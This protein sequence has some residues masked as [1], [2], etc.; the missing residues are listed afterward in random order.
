MA[1]I[2]TIIFTFIGWK[3]LDV[4][5]SKVRR[6]GSIDGRLEKQ[7]LK[8]SNIL[9][10]IEITRTS[11]VERNLSD[12]IEQFANEIKKISATI[13]SYD[14][15]SII[16]TDLT[17]P[18]S[19][20]EE[21]SE[22]NINII[23]SIIKEGQNNQMAIDR[24]LFV[25]QEKSKLL[26]Q[27]NVISELVSDE[28]EKLRLIMDLWNISL[29]LMSISFMFQFYRKS[30]FPIAKSIDALNKEKSNLE[31]LLEETQN[32][33]ESGLWEI[34]F[35]K[36]ETKWS[37]LLY[38]IF[39]VDE[40][41]KPS[42]SEEFNFFVSNDKESLLNAIKD[43]RRYRN[44]HQIEVGIKSQKN[45]FRWI[46][47]DMR[48]VIVNGHVIK[49]IAT[50]EDVSK[51]K[52]LE[53]QFWSLYNGLS[54]PLIMIQDTK[55]IHW[56]ESAQ[57]FLGVEDSTFLQNNHIASF[58][59]MYQSEEL[60]STS[61]FRAIL[62]RLD[63][64]NEITELM[65]LRLVSGEIQN[66]QVRFINFMSA[67]QKTYLLVFEHGREYFESKEKIEDLQ[68]HSQFIVQQVEQIV[69]KIQA[70]LLL[71]STLIEKESKEL[72]SHFDELFQEFDEDINYFTDRL[73]FDGHTNLEVEI[74]GWIQKLNSRIKK[75]F[76]AQKVQ[77][78]GERN[79]KGVFRFKSDDAFNDLL[80][81][82][83][84]VSDKVK[85]RDVVIDW[86]IKD[87]SARPLLEINFLVKNNL[88]I[89]NWKF[90]IDKLSASLKLKPA[91]EFLSTDTHYK[92][93][94]VFG[95][96]VSF[97]SAFEKHVGF[98]EHAIRAEDYLIQIEKMLKTC[99][100][101]L[102]Q[103][104][105]RAFAINTNEVAYV[106]QRL[107]KPDLAL[108]ALKLSQLASSGLYDLCRENWLILND[109]IRRYVKNQHNRHIVKLS[110]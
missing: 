81:I 34:D 96:G 88:P 104:D 54:I 26:T 100:R 58:L 31:K 21:M 106:L 90:S 105:L 108:N 33:I 107:S 87:Q 63:K 28:T 57:L 84:K 98:Y 62:D 71:K 35:S 8:I 85:E 29:V 19:R 50:V 53:N 75:I 102:D 7:V 94:V 73:L 72:K 16:S 109:D 91:I 6:I 32:T 79:L 69:S 77:I 44:R 38:K 13:R 70:R 99:K 49:I 51:M 43:I 66:A 110:A 46:K 76:N 68:Y 55:I 23:N 65:T 27:I 12:S 22:L 40:S 24:I 15:L 39:D 36:R 83:K 17:L 42:L 78:E 80:N 92:Y 47:I 4:L 41:S 93:R 103:S 9:S 95:L 52:E 61:F 1:S 2:V 67:G 56:N 82:A 10:D 5:G 11:E 20:L 14:N 59:P 25:Q 45:Q 60:S 97:S 74:S 37:P 30:Y 86:N 89:S 101:S 48:P 18:I 64:E 3:Y